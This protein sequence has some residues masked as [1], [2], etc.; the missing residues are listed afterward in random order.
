M[1]VRLMVRQRWGMSFVQTSHPI[2]A[3][4][5]RAWRRMARGARYS[6]GRVTRWIAAL[7]YLAGN[8]WRHERELYDAFLE[9]TLGG[10]SG[11]VGSA[12]RDGLRLA[13]PRWS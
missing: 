5:M 10:S 8:T 12:A 9:K 1:R 3:R 11:A 4:S 7:I 6:S 13:W 2:S